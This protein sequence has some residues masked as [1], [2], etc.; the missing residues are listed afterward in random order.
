M[1]ILFLLGAAIFL[2]FI[3]GRLFEKL[4]IP[5]VVGFILTGVFLGDSFTGLLKND[6]LTSLAPV[7][8][9]A[10]GFIGFMVGGELKADVFKK[11]GSRLITILFFEGLIS[12]AL[13]AVAVTV[14]T[15]KAYLGILLGALASATAPAATVDVLW[16]YRA[17]G[18]L[19]TAIFA[20]VALDDGLALILYGFAIA[21]AEALLGA[22]AFSLRLVLVGPLTEIAGSI[23]LGLG[24]GWLAGY[25][26]RFRF[27]SDDTL[28]F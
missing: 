11:H 21:F 25:L 14:F 3:G 10:L 15:G 26:L 1:N 4:R 13:V 17:K 20:I 7:T 2:G 27:N 28:V 5:R 23:F 6:L 16:E 12:A 22:E 9:I 8:E 18:P 24:T 19:T